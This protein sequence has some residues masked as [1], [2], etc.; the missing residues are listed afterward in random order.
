MDSH[1]G[2][3]PVEH[4]D[5]KGRKSILAVLEKGHNKEQHDEGWEKHGTLGKR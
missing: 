5:W 4:L 3:R 2:R 1:E